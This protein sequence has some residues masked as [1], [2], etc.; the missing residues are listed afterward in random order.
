MHKRGQLITWRNQRDWRPLSVNCIKCDIVGPMGTFL[1]L[2]DGC[3]WWEQPW[4]DRRAWH[5]T[6]LI[7]YW[8]RRVTDHVRCLIVARIIVVAAVFPAAPGVVI[9]TVL[10]KSLQCS[11]SIYYCCVYLLSHNRAQL[12]GEQQE[13]VFILF[14]K[15]LSCAEKNFTSK[16]TSNAWYTMSKKMKI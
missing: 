4:I 3:A 12:S 9:C 10:I 16:F 5:I 15:K 13:L 11:C 2:I 8:L 14:N 7:S 6:K 1:A